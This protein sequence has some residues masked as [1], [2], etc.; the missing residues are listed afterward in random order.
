VFNI[1]YFCFVSCT[2]LK[3]EKKKKKKKKKKCGVDFLVPQ[4]LR[5]E[6]GDDSRSKPFEEREND[7][8]QH[9]GLKDPLHVPVRLLT[10]A[11]SKKIKK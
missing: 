3:K 8:N 5:G 10:R 2:K 6:K 4:L 1:L 7:E 11:R 9:A